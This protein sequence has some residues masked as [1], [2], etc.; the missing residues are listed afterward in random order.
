MIWI[1]GVYVAIAAVGYLLLS[2]LLDND[3]PIIAVA[4]A[5][6][7]LSAIMLVWSLLTWGGED[8]EGYEL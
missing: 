3:S 2:H 6:W 8:A 1:C 7:P 4:C 5:L